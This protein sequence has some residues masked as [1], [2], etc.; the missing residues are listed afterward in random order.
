MY[1]FAHSVRVFI[2]A[3]WVEGLKRRTRRGER[4]G[5]HLLGSRDAAETRALAFQ[6][7]EGKHVRLWHMVA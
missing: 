5:P 4:G 6:D 1:V 3:G 2:L 7:K